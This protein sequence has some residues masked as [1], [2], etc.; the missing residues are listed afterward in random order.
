[1]ATVHRMRYRV[2]WYFSIGP[3]TSFAEFGQAFMHFLRD[4]QWAY[5]GTLDVTHGTALL[6]GFFMSGY[7]VDYHAE[8]L[9][10]VAQQ[11][12]EFGGHHHWE[13]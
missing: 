2:K 10:W 3:W 12:W 4:K 13:F 6:D 8:M 1:M 11:N 9:T 5:T 7:P